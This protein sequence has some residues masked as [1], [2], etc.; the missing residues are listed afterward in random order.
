[1]RRGGS[2]GFMLEDDS[3]DD[4][5]RAMVESVYEYKGREKLKRGNSS[6]YSFS[7]EYSSGNSEYVLILLTFISSII[8]LVY[9]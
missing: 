2:R 8:V 7:T 4:R 6:K 1:M 3:M 9:F 5:A